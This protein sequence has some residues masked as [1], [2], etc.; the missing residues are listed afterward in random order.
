MRT[1]VHTLLAA[2]LVLFA[3]PALAQRT[4][5]IVLWN[6]NTITGEVK[7]MQQGQLRFK[8]DHA[9]TIYVKWEF[10]HSVTSTTFFELENGTVLSVYIKGEYFSSG[11]RSS[12]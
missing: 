10:I 2:G 1:H 5:V 6:G 11:A 12:V 3:S 8:T 9:G 4:D 7:G